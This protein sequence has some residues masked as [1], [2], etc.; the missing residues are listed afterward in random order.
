M[1]KK[2]YEPPIRVRIDPKDLANE[3]RVNIRYLKPRVPFEGFPADYPV[4]IMQS[5]RVSIADIWVRKGLV[6]IVEISEVRVVKA[7]KKKA[8]SGQ[9][10]AEAETEAAR[11]ANQ[12]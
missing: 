6:E 8:P 3:E 10:A 4:G 5:Q 9:E 2:K 11:Q 12:G 1:A 7:K